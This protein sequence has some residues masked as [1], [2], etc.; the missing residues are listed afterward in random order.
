[1]KIKAAI[2]DLDNTL[3]D[4]LH[5]N[6]FGLRALQKRFAILRNVESKE[7][8]QE[9]EIILHNAFPA[10]LRGEI[11]VDQS[12]RERIQT[13]VA[14]YG[15]KISA[16][17]AEDGTSLYKEAYKHNQRL[18]PGA[19]GLLDGLLAR[20]ITLGMITNGINPLQQKKL[21]RTGL[22]QYFPN[23]VVAGDVA[24]EKPDPKIFDL[25]L[26]IA[27]AARSEAVYIGDNWE[28][29]VLG[30]QAVGMR[31][32]WINRYGWPCPDPTA[33]HMVTTWQP[34]AKYVDLICNC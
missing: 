15:G 33:C 22:D 4:H 28:A 10:V 21:N 5:A 6:R 31:A 14:T 26:N 3:L 20:G 9:F 7:L 13:L 29:D 16:S 18:I 27:N 1:M 2:F 30:A 17:E 24:L 32:I 25:A 23:P 34:S 8:E 19:I 12:R 11:S